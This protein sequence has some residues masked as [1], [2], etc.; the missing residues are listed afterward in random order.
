MPV[1]LSGAVPVT[2][3]ESLCSITIAHCG[4]AELG[5]IT[6]YHCFEQ[7]LCMLADTSTPCELI[8]RRDEL[9]CLTVFDAVR[10]T[11][12]TQRR[13]CKMKK[14]STFDVVMLTAV[15]CNTFGPVDI[16]ISTYVDLCMFVHP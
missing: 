3:A 5:P 14:R 15:F 8:Q 4:F 12:R 7:M 11:R 13:Q 16:C 9:M 10:K 6:G 1:P 2:P